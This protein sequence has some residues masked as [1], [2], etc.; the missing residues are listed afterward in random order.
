MQMRSDTIIK[1]NVDR[2]VCTTVFLE[3]VW[4]GSDPKIIYHYVEL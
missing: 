1:N 3:G 4:F 2:E